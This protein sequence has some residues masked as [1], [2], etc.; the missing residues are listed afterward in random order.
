MDTEKFNAD[1]AQNT[2][3][4]SPEELITIY[5][6]FPA[7]EGKPNLQITKKEIDNKVFEITLINNDVGDD[8]QGA[9]K[10]IMIAKRI[11]NKWH[12]KKISRNWKCHPGRG[13]TD[14]GTQSCN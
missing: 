6:N 13:N 9:E 5:Y 10:I 2:S 11:V 4:E 3:I 8:V 7:S 1:I 14:W 12:V